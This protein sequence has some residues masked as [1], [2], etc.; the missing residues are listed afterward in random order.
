MFPAES[1]SL[2]E[3]GPLEPQNLGVWGGKTQIPQVRHI[4]C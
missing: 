2:W 1:I 4:E 3:P